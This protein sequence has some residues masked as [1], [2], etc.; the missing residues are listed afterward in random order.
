[1]FYFILFFVKQI[2]VSIAIRERKH[3]QLGESAISTGMA[4]LLG[5]LKLIRSSV[6]C[7]PKHQTLHI[8]DLIWHCNF[9]DECSSSWHVVV[10]IAK[11]NVAWELVFVWDLWWKYNWILVRT[12]NLVGIDLLLNFYSLIVELMFLGSESILFTP[13]TI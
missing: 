2:A 3:W 4:G 7:C 1:M 9:P 11:I 12:Y 13:C 10:I 6:A 5:G 8:F